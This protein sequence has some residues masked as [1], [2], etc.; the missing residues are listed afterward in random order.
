MMKALFA[1]VLIAAC[2]D[3]AAAQGTTGAERSEYAT[4]A[5][6]LQGLRA[7]PGVKISMQ[8]GWTVIEDRSTLSVWS[9]PPVGQRAYPTA[10][11][12]KIVQEGSNI[13]V[14]MKVLCEAPK[15]DCDAVVAE[16][17][18]LNERVRGDLNSKPR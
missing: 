7:K 10:I 3:L 11:Q 1:L 2:V 4:A 13:F 12:R 5:Q 8:S 6:A 14:K 17:G 16:F 18:K 15:P 9:F